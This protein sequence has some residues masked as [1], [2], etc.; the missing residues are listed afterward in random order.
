[1]DMGGR[2]RGEPTSRRKGG[3]KGESQLVMNERWPHG[4]GG[5]GE[6]S[7]LVTEGVGRGLVTWAWGEGRG[8]P[9]GHGRVE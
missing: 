9:A 7:Q 1:M 6:V 3:G 4:H 2:E 8:E 5:K